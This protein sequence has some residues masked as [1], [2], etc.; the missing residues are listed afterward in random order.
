M[1]LTNMLGCQR[2]CTSSYHPAANGLVERLHRQLKASLKTHS[3]PWWTES[4][5]RVLLGIRTAIKLDIGF[6]SAEMVSGTTV[7]LPGEFISLSTDIANL[8]PGDYADYAITCGKSNLLQQGCNKDN[9]VYQLTWTSVRMYLCIMMPWRSPLQVP[10]DGLFR[11]LRRTDKFFAL[12]RNGKKENVSI[13]RQ[14]VAYMDTDLE[15]SPGGAPLPAKHYCQRHYL[16]ANR[17]A[18]FHA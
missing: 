7:R 1:A 4:L 15:R 10:Y 16:S 11:V 8:H 3:N 18:V 2:I 17:H 5:P 14:K 13:D 6:S 12:D 9:H